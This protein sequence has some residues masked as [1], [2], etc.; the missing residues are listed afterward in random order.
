MSASVLL[1]SIHAIG[2]PG[3]RSILNKDFLSQYIRSLHERTYLINLIH[4][5]GTM[6]NARGKH[7]FKFPSY[8][9][10]TFISFDFDFFR[11]RLIPNL[12][13]S[14]LIPI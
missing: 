2:I 8:L 11:D 13:L 10:L 9:R 3:K 1:C 7:T 4:N 6:C 12:Q 14:D 5:Y